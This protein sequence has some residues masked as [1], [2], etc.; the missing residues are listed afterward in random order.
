V[1]STLLCPAADLA[2]RHSPGPT[3]CFSGLVVAPVVDLVAALVVVGKSRR[4]LALAHDSFAV[5]LFVLGLEAV[6]LRNCSCRVGQHAAVPAPICLAGHNSRRPTARNRPVHCRNHNTVDRN[7]RRSPHVVVVVVAA[8]AAVPAVNVLGRN[9]A[10]VV[11]VGNCRIA[12]AGMPS[13]RYRRF[14]PQMRPMV[15]L[16]TI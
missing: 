15:R 11:A 5:E 7:G 8:A 16:V 6:V 13:R 12:V 2:A 9:T 14:K 4:T 3:V 10:A 1:V